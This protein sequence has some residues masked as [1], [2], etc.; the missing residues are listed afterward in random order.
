M[1]M[2]WG[3]FLVS[4]VSMTSVAGADEGAVAGNSSAAANFLDCELDNDFGRITSSSSS[5]AIDGQ[6]METIA[7]RQ[8]EVEGEVQMQ[9]QTAEYVVI[10]YKASCTEQ[11]QR[12]MVL[13][14][15]RSGD[16]MHVACLQREVCV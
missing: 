5:L 14:N 4:L 12:G 7:W 6:P 10:V 1:K 2:F 11:G 15:K 8:M 3:L 9:Y 16:Q 13:I